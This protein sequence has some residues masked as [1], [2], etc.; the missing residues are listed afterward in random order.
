MYDVPEQAVLSSLRTFELHIT[1]TQSSSKKELNK[2]LDWAF[3]SNKVPNRDLTSLAVT[4]PRIP[5]M[6][7][8][9]LKFPA[10]KKLNL[11]YSFV[12]KKYSL[13][14]FPNF[15]NLEWLDLSSCLR[16]RGDQLPILSDKVGKSLRYLGLA[17]MPHF[18]DNDLR[19][20]P[21][22]FPV[23]RTLDLSGCAQI[24]DA[25]LVEWY[26]KHDKN[27]WPKLRKL[28]LKGCEGITKEVV[29]SVR[30]KTRNQLLVDL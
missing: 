15:Q 2:I 25:V 26:M 10:L 14:D 3:P 30:L 1:D 27:E 6:F 28:I 24:T 9:L 8:Q 23:L 16:I 11:S 12:P 17:K 18:T 29:H 21:V 7:P 20:L 4:G 13:Q 19:D 5:I 22:L